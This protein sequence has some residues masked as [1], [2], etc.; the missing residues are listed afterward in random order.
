MTRVALTCAIATLF[1]SSEGLLANTPLR[2]DLSAATGRRD[3]ETT[4]WHEW[5]I[6]EGS[7]VSKEFDGVTVTLES[8]GAPLRGFL[9]KAS[10][11]TGA[12]LAA[13]GVESRSTI[14]IKIAGLAPGKHT[15]A[16]FHNRPG[17]GPTSGVQLQSG[18]HRS[19]GAPSHDAA[20]DDQMGATY[21]PFTAEPGAPAVLRLAA[22]PGGDD[23]SIVLNALEIDTGDPR[24]RAFAPSPAN[25]DEHTDGKSGQVRLSWSAPVD[26]RSFRVYLTRDRDYNAAVNAVRGSDSSTAVQ[27][28]N[29]DEPELPVA[30]LPNDSLQ[31]YCWRIDTTDGQGQVTR[32]DVWTFRVRHLAFP[33]AEGY[34]RFAIG[35]RGGRVF[36]VTTLA[37]DGPGSLRAA[38]G[39]TGPRTIVF[40]VGGRIE[41][42]SRLTLRDNYVTIAGQTAPGSGI[43]I[44]NYNMGMLGAHDNILRYLRV[45]PGDTSGDTLDGMGM[46]SSDHSIIDHCSISWSHDEAFSSRGA[47][48]I[49]LQRTLISEALNIAG[50]RKYEEGKQHGFA[51]SISGDIGS[52]HHNLLAHCAGRNW[53]LA[54][55]ID[56]ANI[57]AGRLDIRNN[58]VYN[59]GY[60]TTDG[61]AKKVQFVANYYKPGPATTVFHMLK[62]ERNHAFGPQDYYVEGN[63]MEGRYGPAP[64]LEGVVAPRDEPL[65]E[66]VYDKPF[67]PSYVQTQSARDAYFDILADV[68]CNVPALDDHDKRVIAETRDGTATFT[69]SRSG[70]PGLPDSQ[71]DVGGWDDYPEE[72]RPADW[73]T[74]DDGIPNAWERNHGLDPNDPA[75]GAVDRNGDGYTNLEEYLNGLATS[76]N[77]AS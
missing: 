44:S 51:A 49:T 55:A 52:F 68:G 41:L 42:K 6:K 45:R 21:V 71:E 25:F 53:S 36:K 67:F 65:S 20:R 60:R 62:P 73:D 14:E 75:D 11:A 3:A 27:I 35:G 47:R 5:E 19:D 15:L 31:H 17:N 28:T 22:L 16:A 9:H 64:P 30:V 54:G 4:G 56:Q 33:G 26:A 34:G 23:P 38:V 58:L 70:L 69:G 77:H 39:A 37:D 66:F 10:L 48:N 76:S 59:W 29:T 50:H 40:D 72:R 74:D 1:L 63:V 12:S 18:E 13:D 46:A 8:S 2:I 24:E 43:C 32:G 61:G 57:H 7:S